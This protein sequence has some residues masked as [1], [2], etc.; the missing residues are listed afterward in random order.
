[1]I[2]DPICAVAT[3]RGFSA[4]AVIRCS[5]ENVW[6][7]ITPFLK[8]KHIE[9]WRLYLTEFTV[10]GKMVDEVTVVFYRAP[11]SYT[12]ED[13]VELIFHGSPIVL[14][15]VMEEL[16]KV[17]FREALPGEFTRRAV[18]NGKMDLLKAE[19]I[20]VLVEAKTR[21]AHEAA[22][23][24]YQGKLG[25]V[26]ES[27]RQLLIEAMAEVE[28]ELN[29]PGEVEVSTGGVIIRLEKAKERLERLVAHGENGITLTEGIRTVIAG[30]TNVGKSTLLNA[31]LRKDRAIVTDIPGTT[32]DTIEEALSID[33]TYFKIVDTAGIREPDNVVERIGIDRSKKEI[34]MADLVIFMVDLTDPVPDLKLFE[35]FR[36]KMK[37]YV[38]L[39]NK[40]DLVSE[41]PGDLELCI[42]ANSGGS[43]RKL[44]EKMLEKTADLTDFN[45]GELFVTERQKALT[46]RALEYLNETLDA[47][48]QGITMDIISSFLHQTIKTLDELT[49][50]YLQDDL[51]DTIFSN[52]CVGK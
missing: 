26:V 4:L 10:D 18:M 23:F 35:Q 13:M 46:Y 8:V 43:L 28:V 34:E 1:M 49:G 40:L 52:F 19:A 27:I 20:E 32:R 9:P 33:G 37:R 5:G 25:Q 16:F 22:S 44:E 29:Y 39:G 42:S 3:P 11:R 2:F 47:L 7:L 48:K 6:K 38:L 15:I 24:T 51:L 30:R 36:P 12:G 41:C 31:L 14:K 17:G 21:K 45:E 50:K